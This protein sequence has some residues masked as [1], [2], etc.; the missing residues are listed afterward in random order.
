LTITRQ[1]NMS[2][3]MMNSSFDQRIRAR[4]EAFTEE[5]S[6][7]VRQSA[8]ES[9]REALGAPASNGRRTR[10]RAVPERATRPQPGRASTAGRG[11]A[12][13]RGAK[14]PPE[15]LVRLTERLHQYIQSHPGQRIEEIAR[16]METSTKELNLPA[17]KLISGKQV[18]TKGHK[19]ATQYFAK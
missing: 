8:V 9:L 2:P 15:E 18:K 1:V 16:G 6:A 10:G 13:E 3:R 19:R 12:R 7:L 14:R 4:I 17:K 5:L 11:R